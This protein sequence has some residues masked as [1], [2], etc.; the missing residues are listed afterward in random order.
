MCGHIIK[1]FNLSM[2]D[3]TGVCGQIIKGSSLSEPIYNLFLSLLHPF[4]PAGWVVSPGSPAL[5]VEVPELPVCPWAVPPGRQLLC[6]AQPGA[7]W[8]LEWAD[9]GG[10]EATSGASPR[11][12]AMRTRVF[13]SSL[14]PL[15]Q[16]IQKMQVGLGAEGT[17][18]SC[19]LCS[20]GKPGWRN[21]LWSE[22]SFWWRKKHPFFQVHCQSSGQAGWNVFACSLC[23]FLFLG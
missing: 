3:Q 7:S 6:W 17:W 1:S 12:N 23:C 21:V 20:L 4:L 16:G 5:R 11:V 8:L 19:R 18:W 13:G 2:P 9:P 10:L 15:I 22:V 14:L